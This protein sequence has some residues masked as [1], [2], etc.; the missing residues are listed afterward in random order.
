MLVPMGVGD[1]LDRAALV[2]GDREAV[3]DEPGV[4]GSGGAVPYPGVRRR[5]WGVARPL[6]ALGVGEGER[7]AIVSPNAARF[8]CSFWGV[9]A[10][11][12]I[13]VPVNY[14]LHGEEGRYLVEHS[15]A[16]VV[17]VDPEYE[18]AMAAVGAEHHLV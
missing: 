13:L 9:S 17:L 10:F 16:A 2:Y 7:V 1:F 15:G 5:A 18:D 4:P 6:D 11:G 8:L 3:A 14:R 12:R